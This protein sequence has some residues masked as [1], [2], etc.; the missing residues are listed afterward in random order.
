M[1]KDK[2]RNT[3][4][5]KPWKAGEIVEIR[6]TVDGRTASY[7]VGVGEASSIGPDGIRLRGEMRLYDWSTYVDGRIDRQSQA[8]TRLLRH[9]SAH[10]SNAACPSRDLAD[11]GGEPDAV[12]G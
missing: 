4:T 7:V 2:G 12:V 5:I 11:E 6:R 3:E 8:I 10:C 1:S 9:V